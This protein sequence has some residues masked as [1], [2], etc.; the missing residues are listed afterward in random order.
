VTDTADPDPYR[1][2]DPYADVP[3]VPE[4]DDPGLEV[5]VESRSEGFSNAEPELEA[6]PGADE[7]GD[8][9]GWSLEDLNDVGF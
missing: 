4:D 9:E 7:Y 5:G 8:A 1:E 3:E 2:P 6:G